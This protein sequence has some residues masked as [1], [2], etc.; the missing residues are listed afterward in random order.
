MPC[1]KRRRKNLFRHSKYTE[2][3]EA[4]A[5]QATRNAQFGHSPS[6]NIGI[7]NYT[8]LSERAIRDDLM[9]IHGNGIGNVIGNQKDNE[10]AKIISQYIGLF[11]NNN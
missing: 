3:Y 4:G 11:T 6:S 10:N 9:R 1:H 8:H 2:V 7:A 5:K